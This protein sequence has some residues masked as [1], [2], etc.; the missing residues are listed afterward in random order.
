V[1]DWRECRLLLVVVDGSRWLFG[2]TFGNSKSTFAS[3][4]MILEGRN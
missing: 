1:D 2:L 3:S 4:G